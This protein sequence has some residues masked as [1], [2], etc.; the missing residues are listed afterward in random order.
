MLALAGALAAAD[1]LDASRLAVTGGRPRPAIHTLSMNGRLR[2]TADDGTMRDGT[3]AIRIALP[4]R[5]VRV[6]TI[7]GTRRMSGFDGDRLLTRSDGRAADRLKVERAQLTR[8]LLGAAAIVVADERVDIRAAGDEAFPDTRALDVTAR[9]WSLRYVMDAASALPLRLVYF[10]PQRG[11]TITSFADRRDVDGYLLPHRIT[12]TT[13]E[14]VLETL[15]FD[16]M[17]VNPALTDADFK[18]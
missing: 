4:R 7:G 16:E 5:F 6:D 2:V 14:R 10:A 12:T 9:S 13:A 18:P 11:T 1:P 3:V 17:M 15:M 8:L